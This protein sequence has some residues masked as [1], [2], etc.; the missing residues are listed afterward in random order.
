MKHK[1]IALVS[2]SLLTMIL[3]SAVSFAVT[4]VVGN[5]RQSRGYPGHNAEIHGDLFTL[6]GTGSI[7]G[8]DGR[9]ASGFW[10][11]K[12]S[13]DMVRNFNTLAQAQGY[14]LPAGS[15]RVIPNIKDGVNSCG[16]TVTF[17][18]P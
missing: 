10:I 15:Y 11:E 4:T 6:P 8:V 13:G 18:C 2:L 17:T 1:R 12:E 16:V 9:G 7:T 5:G 3:W 14:S